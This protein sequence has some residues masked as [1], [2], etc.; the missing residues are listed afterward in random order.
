MKEI[1][2]PVKRM[3]GRETGGA[4]LWRELLL[5]LGEVCKSHTVPPSSVRGL[6]RDPSE[7]LLSFLQVGQWWSEAPGL[8]ALVAEPAEVA[9]LG[10]LH[11]RVCRDQ[12]WGLLPRTCMWASRKPNLARSHI[13]PA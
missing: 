12:G 7:S 9:A 13:D 3:F 4:V 10:H 6:Q 2:G 5:D 8:A 11:P 1:K